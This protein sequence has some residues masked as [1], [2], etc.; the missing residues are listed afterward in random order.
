MIEQAVRQTKPLPDF[1]RSA[2]HEVFLILSGTIQNPAFLRFIER[3]GEDALSRLQTL[4][5]LAL[6]ALAHGR[7][8]T[9]EMKTRVPDLIDAGAVESQGRGKGQ[10][11]FLS[12]ELY[13]V[14]GTPG[15]HTRQQGLDHETNKE[16]L[17]KHLK[18]CGQTGSKMSELE[19]VLPAQS[20][21]SIL[22]MLN[23]LRSENRILKHGSGGFSRWRIVLILL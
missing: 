18:S 10:R 5:F 14:M 11:R 15:V 16:L 9:R 22:R 17:I 8:L 21:R 20:R 23:E 19:Q 7:E 2:A 12:R 3:L 6:D 13:E 1:S 4:D